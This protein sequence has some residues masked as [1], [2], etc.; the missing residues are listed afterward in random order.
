MS[1]IYFHT[2]HNDTAEVSGA[3]RAHASMTCG[4]LTILAL[5]VDHLFEFDNKPSWIRQFIRKDSYL[6]DYAVGDKFFV[7][8][9]KSALI[10]GFTDVLIENDTVIESLAFNLNT[11][12]KIGND[13]IKFMARL[14]GQCEIHGFVEGKNRNWL[15]DIIQDG[16]DKKILR[17]SIHGV[18]NGWNKVIELLRSDNSNPVVMSYSVC[19]SFP[20]SSVTTWKPKYDEKS[21]EDLHDEWYDLPRNEQWKMSM[22]AIRQEPSLELT[23][24]TWNDFYFVGNKDAF[25]LKSLIKEKE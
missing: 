11:A 8:A 20:N 1:R 7:Q 13:V 21:G 9:L 2:E 19:E 15:A 23:P 17:E 18:S 12:L 3:E 5:Q 24:D 4:D 14:H 16:L 25:Y 22:D 10:T 6:S